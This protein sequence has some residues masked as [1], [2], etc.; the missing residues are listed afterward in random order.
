MIYQVKTNILLNVCCFESSLLI[1]LPHWVGFCMNTVGQ[2][3]NKIIKSLW[4]LL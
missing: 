3:V 4:G 1:H 2:L